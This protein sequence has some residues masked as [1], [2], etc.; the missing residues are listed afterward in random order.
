MCSCWDWPL[1]PTLPL[2]LDPLRL[3]VM[4]IHHTEPQRRWQGGGWSS[5]RR[6]Y[7]FET[8]VAEIDS[9]SGRLFL[10]C[11]PSF[12]RA[13]SLLRLSYT[14]KHT[15]IHAYHCLTLKGAQCFFSWNRSYGRGAT[16]PGPGCCLFILGNNCHAT[17]LSGLMD[18][19]WWK[20]L[21]IDKC[22]HTFTQV[23]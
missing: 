17:H 19:P 15:F 8:N 23:H 11:C 7:E 4:V 13:L 10:W 3:P 20:L 12:K 18:L 5:A 22:L 9:H 6:W 1:S 2:L 16:Q 21:H 14:L